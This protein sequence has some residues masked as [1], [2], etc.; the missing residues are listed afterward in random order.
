MAYNE[1]LAARIREALEHHPK[2]EEK[3]M[4]SGLAFM[5]D[6]KMCINVSGDD[7]MCRFDPLLHDTVAEKNGFR[8]MIMKG[9][10]LKGYCYV[11]EEGFKSKKDFDYWI[12][13]CLS[14]NS[15]AK[16]SKKKK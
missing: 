7:L 11:S 2:V 8:S 15:K 16:S 10:E 12:N 6:E 13:L 14:F 1:K 9:K 4:F 3:N 5:V